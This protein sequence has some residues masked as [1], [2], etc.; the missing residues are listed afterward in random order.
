MHEFYEFLPLVEFRVM[1]SGRKL[2]KNVSAIL[3]NHEIVMKLI[4]SNDSKE[5]KRKKAL[6]VYITDGGTYQIRLDIIGKAIFYILTCA[7]CH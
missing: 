5:K 3:G 1:S 6:F 7:K 4:Y 2:L